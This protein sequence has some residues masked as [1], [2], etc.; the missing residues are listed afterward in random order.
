M[1][2]FPD[3]LNYPDTIMTAEN[4]FYFF[5]TLSSETF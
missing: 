1:Y 3:T 4:K 5:L 2:N